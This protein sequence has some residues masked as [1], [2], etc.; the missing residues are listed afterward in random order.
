MQLKIISILL[1]TILALSCGRR[2]DKEIKSNSPLTK[3]QNSDTITCKKNLI[4]E[5]AGSA[6]LQRATG[7]FLISGNDTSGF[8]P[9]FN[10]L[11]ENRKI[12]IDLNLPYAGMSIPFQGKIPINDPK[13]Y[14][15]WYKELEIILQSASKDYNLDL[16]GSISLGRLILTG[17]LA[18]DIT[19]EY[20]KNFGAKE[21]IATADYGEIE[22]FLLSSK[23]AEDFNKLLLPYRLRSKKISI[24]KTFFTTR[25]DLINNSITETLPDSIPETILD[26]ITWI[27]TEP[28]GSQ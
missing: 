27:I 6:Y 7:Y 20:K 12:N 14:S 25:E 19:R 22:K 3:I 23:L 9:I 5:I 26:C 21:K 11:K 24:E 1:L 17:D 10:E 16:T 2:P 28:T 13:P 18:I 8:M 4:R 15:Q